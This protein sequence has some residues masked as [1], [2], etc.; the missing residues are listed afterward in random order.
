MLVLVI[1]VFITTIEAVSIL[2]YSVLTCAELKIFSLK[3][4]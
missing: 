1:Q 4:C 2:T 3:I